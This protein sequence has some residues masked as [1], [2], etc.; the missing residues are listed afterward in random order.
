MVT[1]HVMDQTRSKDAKTGKM[2]GAA[3]LTAG[4]MAGVPAGAAEAPAQVP[5]VLDPRACLMLIEPPGTSGAEY[6]PGVDVHGRPV[7]PAEGPAGRPDYGLPEDIVIN[8]QID[9]A[10]RLGLGGGGTLY[11]PKA[12]LGTI[13]VRDGVVRLNGVPLNA[14]GQEELR[15]ACRRL[16][17][18]D[19][20]ARERK[21][22]SAR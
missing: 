12:Q 6:R 13:T 10:E 16:G 21:P 5:V 18:L 8:L 2:A 22:G 20:A 3:L 11:E 1:E 4:L 19:R 7:T 9:V 17:V 15:D 14:R